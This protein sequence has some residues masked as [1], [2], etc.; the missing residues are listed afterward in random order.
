MSGELDTLPKITA[1]FREKLK[2]DVPSPQTDLLQ[3]GLMDSL[4]FVELLVHLEQEFGLT[5]SIQ[6]LEVENVR[7]LARIADF[8]RSQ[9][10]IGNG[11]SPS[12]CHG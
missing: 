1:I 5:I 6:N 10:P 4:T 11:T 7:S 2:L 3:A 12:V 8:V 9:R